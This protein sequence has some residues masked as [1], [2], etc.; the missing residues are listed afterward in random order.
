MSERNLQRDWPI[1]IRP[2]NDPDA[3]ARDR[4]YWLSR[5]PAERVEAVETL[6][7]QFYGSTPQLTE[8][9][10]LF[11]GHRVEYLVVGAHALAHHGA[12]RMTGDLDLL[13][14]PATENAQR[15]LDALKA[16]GFGSLELSTDDFSKPD[17]VV[18][19]GF[20]PARIDLL[21]T[22]S[23]VTWAEAESRSVQGEMSRVPVRFLGRDELIKNKRACGRA[24]DIADIERLS[25]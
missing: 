20:P 1:V 21:T 12:P 5:P 3:Y 10:E 24:Q 18:Q 8:L 22:L 13:I 6:Q 23:G 2:L 19:L 9:L 17:R 7:R 16:F 4:N 25:S 14:R 11:N 15:V